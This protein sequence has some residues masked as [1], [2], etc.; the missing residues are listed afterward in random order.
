MHVSSNL[1]Y[2]SLFLLHTSKHSPKKIAGSK[3]INRSQHKRIILKENTLFV[4]TFLEFVRLY[5][6][7][8]R[9][10]LFYEIVFCL[11]FFISNPFVLL[12]SGSVMSKLAWK[13]T[14]LGFNIFSANLFLIFLYLFDVA[15]GW[16]YMMF[17]FTE[18]IT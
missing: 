3:K 7:F 8:V 17:Y 5:Q 4:T 16:K 6:R 14:L 12:S 10:M 15:Q 18:N 11:S 1:L 13:Y 2:L 9:N